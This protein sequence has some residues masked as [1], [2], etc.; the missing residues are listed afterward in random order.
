MIQKILRKFIV[1]CFLI[2][3]QKTVL[4]ST[5]RENDWEVTASAFIKSSPSLSLHKP[6]NC[7]WK[8]NQKVTL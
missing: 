3:N 7:F 4:F 1:G 2:G 5:F 8:L 6:K